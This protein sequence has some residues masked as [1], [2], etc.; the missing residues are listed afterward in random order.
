MYTFF[1]SPEYASERDL[2]DQI[3]LVSRNPVINGLLDS[4]NGLL[5]VLNKHR[6]VLAL[7]ENL[8]HVVGIRN[9]TKVL[10]LRPGEMLNCIHLKD[11]PGGCGTGKF[12]PTCGAAIAIVASQTENRPVSRECALTVNKKGKKKDIFLSVKSH[13]ITF[14][15]EKLILLFLQDITK[16][17]NWEMMERVFFHDLNNLITPLL[18]SSEILALK[19]N[20]P[21]ASEIYH[22]AVRL[23]QEIKMQQYISQADD[24]VY[25]PIYTE[26]PLS[27]IKDELQRVFCDHPAAKG[28]RIRFPDNLPNLSLNSDMNLILR[29]LSNMIMNALEATPEGEE[30]TFDVNIKGRKIIFSIW[31]KQVIPEKIKL[32]I[33][34]RHFSTKQGSGRGFGTYSMKL[35]GETYL[36]GRVQFDSSSEDGTTFQLVLPL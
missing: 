28:K 11:T 5:A 35:F 25:T 36:K 7:N 24:H 4:V 20:D 10:G 14:N 34:Q 16:Q 23:A 32:R 26:I 9:P 18:G 22:L 13:P 21:R 27:S 17:H 15:G 12:C 30:I 19:S 1:A 2:T 33:F 6:Q 3:E 29:V 8:L 31:N